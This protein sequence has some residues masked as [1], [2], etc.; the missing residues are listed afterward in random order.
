MV[1]IRVS[2]VDHFLE[3]GIREQVQNR[4]RERLILVR[5]RVRV[6]VSIVG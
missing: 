6:R 5:V 3:R 4:G 1:F 2:G